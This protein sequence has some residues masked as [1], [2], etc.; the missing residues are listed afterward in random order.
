MVGR[1]QEIEVGPMCGLSNVIYWLEKRGYKADDAVV[2][3]VF[4]AAKASTRVLTDSE[5]HDVAKHASAV[6]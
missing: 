3:A 4:K 5:V 6:A 1:E 2:Q